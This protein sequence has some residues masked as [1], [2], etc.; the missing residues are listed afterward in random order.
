MAHLPGNRTF[1]SPGFERFAAFHRYIT[2][3]LVRYKLTHSMLISWRLPSLFLLALLT[4]P[5]LCP[6][7]DPLLA[8][9]KKVDSTGKGEVVGVSL[10]VTPRKETILVT[11][12][13]TPIP[14][15]ESERAVDSLNV[16]ASPL[17][18]NT[19]TDYLKLLPSLD[20][21]Q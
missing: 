17:L 6:A 21:R 3:H 13:F 4:L 1:A 14:L 9:A 20:L 5:G 15:E 19:F 16:A 18:F 2:D 11:G 12:T 8:S 10:P 7:Q